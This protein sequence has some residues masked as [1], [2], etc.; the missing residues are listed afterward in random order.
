MEFWI[1]DHK[2]VQLCLIVDVNPKT[3]MPINKWQ[4]TISKACEPETSETNKWK[5]AWE[6]EKPLDKAF[7]F[8]IGSYFF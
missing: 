6:R 4:S 8:Y 3:T 2:I 5:I 1:P 7:P